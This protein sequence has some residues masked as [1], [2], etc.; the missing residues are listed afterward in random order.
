MSGWGIFIGAAIV[1]ALGFGMLIDR[2]V[3]TMPATNGVIFVIVLGGFVA[4]LVAMA[5][6]LRLP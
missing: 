2:G 1:V 6:G 3:P 4:L 5:R